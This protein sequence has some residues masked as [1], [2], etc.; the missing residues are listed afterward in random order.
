MNTKKTSN[1]KWKTPF[2]AFCKVYGPQELAEDISKLAKN[3]GEVNKYQVYRWVHG[4]S[5]V[6]A[7]YASMI[8]KLSKG[9]I[10]L[11]LIVAH[12]ESARGAA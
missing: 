1:L 6:P 9:K 3:P 11:D 5:A 7:M 10:S 12:T 4:K 2:G 8:T